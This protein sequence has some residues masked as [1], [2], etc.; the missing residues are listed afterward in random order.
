MI[1]GLTFT[2]GLGAQILSAAGYFYHQHVGQEVVGITDYFDA[3]QR[4]AEPGQIG[5]V[6]HWGWDLDV[7][8]LGRDSFA[9]AGG[10]A[11]R[12]IPDGAEKG[13]YAKRGLSVAAIRAR[14]PIDADSRQFVQDMFHGERYAC[15]HIRRGDYINVAS[16]MIRDEAFFRIIKRVSRLVPN[17]LVCSDTPISGELMGLLQQSGLN[18][19]TVHGGPAYLSHGIMRL[20]DILVCANSQFSFSAAALRDDDQLTFVHARHDGDLDSEYNRELR[21]IN[22]FQALTHLYE[23]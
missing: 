4:I 19:K 12:V 20:S 2:G 13:L 11:V 18:V 7:Y 16:Y 23:H 21:A 14:F 8:G 5:Q 6:T 9:A 22:E 17:I 1:N 10:R 15:V 3:A